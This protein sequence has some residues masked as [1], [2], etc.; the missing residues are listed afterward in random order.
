MLAKPSVNDI[1]GKIGTRY[2]VALAVAKRARQISDERIE[3][4]DPDISDPVDVASKE[5]DSGKVVVAKQD[6]EVNDIV[7]DEEI[8]AGAATEVDELN[9][10]AETDEAEDVEEIVE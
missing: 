2:E 3:T 8:E 7:V 1:M 5:I 9:E 10:V 4:G 6:Q